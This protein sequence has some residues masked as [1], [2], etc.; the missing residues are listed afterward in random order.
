MVKKQ[1][2]DWDFFENIYHDY[3]NIPLYSLNNIKKKL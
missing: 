2:E 1:I 3:S